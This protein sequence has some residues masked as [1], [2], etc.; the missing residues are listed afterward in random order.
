MLK[1]ASTFVIEQDSARVVGRLAHLR[2]QLQQ[3]LLVRGLARWL[4]L[5]LALAIIDFSLDRVFRFDQPQRAV[6][7]LAALGLLGWAA[8][9]WLI[10]PLAASLSDDTLAL[11]IEQ[12]QP[13]LAQ[14]LISGL[15]LARADDPLA[16]G[17][18]PVLVQRAVAEAARLADELPWD[19][20]L[21]Q[22]RFRQAAALLSASGLLIAA[23]G[24]GS[25]LAPPLNTWFRRNLLISR[26]TWPTD[27]I[28][29]MYRLNENGAV[30]FPRG[31]HWTQVV[32]VGDNSRIIPDAVSLDVRE[33]GRQS[34]LVMRRVNSRRFEASFRGV[35]QPFEMR[36]HGGDAITPWIPVRLVDPP[37]LTAVRLLATS[38][39]YAGSQPEELPAG[40][41]TYAL[42]AGSKL[43]LEATP[44]KKLSLAS[45][46]FAG[47][48]LLDP[49]EEAPE[50]Q[51][52]VAL[53]PVGGA[54][55]IDLPADSLVAGDY[56]FELRDEFGFTSSR[57]WSFVVRRRPDEP[58]QV[59]VELDGISGIVTPAARI[60]M[61]GQA[62]DD[63][64]LAW[65]GCHV[66]SGAAAESA[67]V[68]RDTELTTVNE[69]LAA[70]CKSAG[71]PVRELSFAETLDLAPLQLTS[72][73]SVQFRIAARDNDDV[74]GPNTGLSSEIMLRVVTD[75]ELLAD[76]LR[77]EKLARLELAAAV[78][79][80]FDLATESRALAA[81]L[82]GAALSPQQS[83]EL[84][85][86]E[87]RQ[88]LTSDGVAG[89]AD[90]LRH[91]A[92]EIVNNRLEEAG[93]RMHQRLSTQIAQPLFAIARDTLPSAVRSLS[94]ARLSQE[95]GAQHSGL[96]EAAKQQSAAAQQMQAIVEHM[97]QA[98]G[99]QEAV[100]L[101]Y[102]I[103]R[104]QTE[105]HEQ[106]RQA[107]AERIR[108]IL[109]G[110]DKRP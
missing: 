80:Q 105:V 79:E 6:L 15:Q 57:P 95:P 70:L 14:R 41:S 1:T 8:S 104:A 18:S 109:E 36:A 77:R 78:K 31:Q 91:M 51:A 94:A 21:D 17:M 86:L 5:L 19:S 37:E 50:V 82:G 32:N 49:D 84:A 75:A 66:R 42:L 83:S 106:T 52:S 93:G 85:A 59:T 22:R 7:L 98:E 48:R 29:V 88:R 28:L 4:W 34:T 89:I 68:E 26:H 33:A 30:V 71:R 11:A 23:L 39:R 76:L 54:L 97:V 55:G 58:P 61:Q 74:L 62:S 56:Q 44:N 102:E 90:R 35:T 107:L 27:T 46:R 67:S 24:V 64:G 10:A 47:Q 87:R 96:D 108:R 43:H 2:R 60:P 38:P 101:L 9:R 20:L 3:R 53:L 12:L 25:A 100:Q 92:Q 69:R 72:G 65:L 63:Y 103:E 99:F 81:A 16:R 45:L 110:T 40:Q 13:N 73:G